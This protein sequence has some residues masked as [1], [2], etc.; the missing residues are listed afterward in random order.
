MVIEVICTEKFFYIISLTLIFSEQELF[1]INLKFTCFM[2]VPY[3]RAILIMEWMRCNSCWL[4]VDTKESMFHLT[5][6]G[7][8][9][10]NKCIVKGNFINYYCVFL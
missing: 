6:C 4:K 3:A 1:K 8:I 9:F 10:C 2:S 7:H 5:Q